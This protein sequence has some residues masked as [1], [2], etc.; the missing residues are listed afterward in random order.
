MLVQVSVTS[1]RRNDAGSIFCSNGFGGCRFRSGYVATSN[2][3]L[4]D[5]TA[6]PGHMH[7]IL[8]TVLGGNRMTNQQK[9]I[10]LQTQL[11][12]WLDEK[13]RIKDVPASLHS[14]RVNFHIDRLQKKMYPLY[15][16][17]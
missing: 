8:K 4:K 1:I 7:R 17:K 11:T 3:F 10:E 14:K 12:G 6:L 5:K 15:D 9:L 16:N 2:G 13:R